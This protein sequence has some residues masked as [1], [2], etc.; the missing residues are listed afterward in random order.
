MD[1]YWLVLPNI[2]IKETL[3]GTSSGFVL[4]PSKLD[5]WFN[6][7]TKIHADSSFFPQQ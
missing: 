1:G 2:D 6:I 5:D 4:N 3:Q 7:C